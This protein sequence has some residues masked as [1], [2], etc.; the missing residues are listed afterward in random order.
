MQSMLIRQTIDDLVAGREVDYNSLL[1]SKHNASMLKD[2]KDS[3]VSGLWRYLHREDLLG[4]AGK[5]ENSINGSFVDCLPSKDCAS[6]CYATK[7]NYR[8]SNPIIKSELVNWAVEN[9][10]VRA[11]SIASNNYKATAEYYQNKAL[12]L[13]DMGDGSMSWLPFIKQMNKEGI[14]LQIFSKV[15]IQHPSYKSGIF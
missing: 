8:F 10:P 13:F 2:L 9:D 4:H 1:S 11:A 6:F 14:R 12:R 3:G 5:P 7:G 15:T